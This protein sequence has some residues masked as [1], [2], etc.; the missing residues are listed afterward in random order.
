M[1]TFAVG[2]NAQKETISFELAMANRH[3]L[4][5][6][7]TGTGKTV[8]LQM[9]VENLSKAGVT[10]FAADIKG[11][12][13]GLA[14]PADV[15]PKLQK[16]LN[17]LDIKNYAPL[18][19]PVIFWDLYGKNGHPLRAT[20]SDFGP[21]LL[22]RLLQLNDTQQGVLQLI[23]SIA[24]DQAMPL[25]DL[26]DLRSMLDWTADNATS[27]KSS[28]GSLPGNTL[29]IIQRKIIT[30]GDTG[31]DKFFGEPALDI[32]NLFTQQ[33]DGK[34]FIHLLDATKLIVDPQL[35]TTFLLWLLSELFEKM[36]EVGDRDKPK[37]VFFFDE[38]HLLFNAAP[39]P[40]LEKIEQ[41]VR[42]IRSK[43]VGVFFITQ[44][45]LDIPQTVLGQL[46]NRVQHALRAFTPKDQKSV[47]T[48]AQ[49]FRKNPNLNTEETIT[50]LGVGEALVSFLDLS[51]T[52]TMVDQ[53][54]ILPPVSR[55]G[56]VTANERQEIIQHSPFINQYENK[57]ERESAYEK[58]N[59]K[60]V[61]V[62]KNEAS[63]QQENPLKEAKRPRGRPRDTLLQ[64]V[65][66]TSSKTFATQVGRQ[67]VKGLL[68][69]FAKK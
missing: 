39:K 32:N 47:K 3:G 10:I 36:P 59:K 27:L 63:A 5:A 62:E 37:L 52:P 48:A 22:G 2:K 17:D 6:G 4:I 54:A 1:S 69:M 28:Y 42:L 13:S 64:T 31:C 43:G 12:L 40:L 15:Q 56:P 49:T 18:G 8:T 29:G 25:I 21:L 46:S 51:G 57:I 66:K 33:S 60:K 14:M 45:P 38:A 44:S 53:V 23:F 55:I 26:K 11:D 30:L 19:N 58:L 24:E 65:V 41:L 67:I 61:A 35:Y 68:N 20:I 16:R 34:G 9:L 7:A 50:T